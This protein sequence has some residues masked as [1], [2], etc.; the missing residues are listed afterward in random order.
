MTNSDRDRCFC[1][2][3][4]YQIILCLKDG[5]LVDICVGFC[6]GCNLRTQFIVL[7]LLVFKHFL[8]ILVLRTNNDLILYHEFPLQT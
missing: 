5:L 2:N 3:K 6:I 1:P 7:I 8:Y 4:I